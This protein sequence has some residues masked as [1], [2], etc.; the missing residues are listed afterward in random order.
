MSSFSSFFKPFKDLI[1]Y[2]I[3]WKYTRKDWF[4]GRHACLGYDVLKYFKNLPTE[5]NFQKGRVDILLSYWK[6]KTA[7]PK[8][9]KVSKFMARHD[10]LPLIRQLSFFYLLPKKAPNFIFMDSFSELVDQLFVNRAE[11]WKFTCAYND[12]NHGGGFLDFYECMGLLPKEELKKY[13]LDLII[14]FE[15]RYGKVP[16]Y[17]LHFPIALEKREVFRERY[18]AI[19][20]AIDQLSQIY[21]HLHSIKINEF[22]VSPPTHT[23]DT[24]ESLNGFPYHYDTKT[25]TEFAKLLDLN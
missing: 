16:I 20:S 18:R 4:L 19:I 9:D 7:S 6:D 5:V 17:F 11:G 8:A 23:Q 13:Y 10:V 15:D 2:H 21:S 1:K 14:F 12:I 22:E 24:P 25:Y 3:R